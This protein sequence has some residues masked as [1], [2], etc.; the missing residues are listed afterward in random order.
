MIHVLARV[1]RSWFMIYNYVEQV[2]SLSRGSLL[3][4][5]QGTSFTTT[6]ETRRAQAQ[7]HPA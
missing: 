5:T 1:V 4:P 7:S 2:G 3:Y 6:H